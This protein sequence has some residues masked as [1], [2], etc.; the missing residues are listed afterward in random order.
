MFV[1]DGEFFDALSTQRTKPSDA[2]FIAYCSQRFGLQDYLAID[3]GCGN[4]RF[5]QTIQ[6]QSRFTIGIDESNYLL[7]IAKSRQVSNTLLYKTDFFDFFRNINAQTGLS[8]FRN[9]TSFG[10]S[11]IED[12]T[13][14][15]RDIARAS[16]RS[17]YFFDTFV[18]DYFEK[19]PKVERQQ[20][21]GNFAF[22]EKYM[23]DKLSGDLHC[24]WTYSRRSE[25]RSIVFDL[26]CMT[27]TQIIDLVQSTGLF[28]IAAFA[29]MDKDRP[30]SQANVNSDRLVLVASNV[31]I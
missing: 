29:G 26:P 8:V 25:E 9:Y 30:F 28:V 3:V 5:L 27:S 2:Q 24:T 13:M 22:I 12:E 18:A 17:F 6:D 7:D 23:Y 20:I 11:T 31:L 1:E 10:Y 16:D 15:L 21:V 4:G 14:L 19:N